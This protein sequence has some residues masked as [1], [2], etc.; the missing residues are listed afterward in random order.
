MI[1]YIALMKLK[2]DTPLEKLDQIESQARALGKAIAEVAKWSCGR[3][4]NWES[5]Y[6]NW[7]LVIMADFR[8]ERAYQRYREHPEHRAFREFAGPYREKSLTMRYEANYPRMG[9]IKYRDGVPV[10]IARD[11]LPPLE[12]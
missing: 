3:C 7:T 12:A 4:I 2:D 8:D 5:P 1:R 9:L 10:V 6:A 11:R